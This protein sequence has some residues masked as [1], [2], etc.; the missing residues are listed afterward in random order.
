MDIEDELQDLATR[1]TQAEMERDRLVARLAGLYAERDALAAIRRP[2][3]DGD[4]DVIDLPDL[5]GMK[6]TEAV[7]A[8]LR[9]AEGTLGPMAVFNEM[10]RRGQWD[11]SYPVVQSTLQYLY[12]GGRI[13]RLGHGEYGLSA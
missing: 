6:R 7:L 2:T 4:A 12:R 3:T 8:V 10:R 11:V 5:R 9:D 1:I 13:Q